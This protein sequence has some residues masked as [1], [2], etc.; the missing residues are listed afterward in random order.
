[1]REKK[2]VWG[3]AAVAPKEYP[4]EIYEGALVNRDGYSYNFGPIYGVLRQGWGY[5]A[6]GMGITDD[7]VKL[8]DQLK[9]TWYSVQEQQFYT[10]RWKL[11]KNLI[12]KVWKEVA[13]NL[14]TK[15]KENFKTLIVGMAPRGQV[16]LWGEGPAQVLLG[17]FQA[18]DTII[19]QKDANPDFEHFFRK[20]YRNAAYDPYKL[21][22][23]ELYS[24]LQK[25]GWPDPKIYLDFNKKYPW[26]FAI[27]GIEASEDD[28][29][30]YSSFNGERAQVL[31][32]REINNTLPKAAPEHIYAC[33]QDPQHNQWVAT[34]RFTYDEIKSSFEHFGSSE[35]IEFLFK[36]DKNAGQFTIYLQSK[37]KKIKLTGYEPEL[38]RT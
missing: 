29:F 34:I 3:G 35:K 37:N 15:S 7:P 12:T 2:Y 26:K 6:K 11:D 33:W 24:K 14:R 28:Y 19:S 13:I 10:G 23:P 38:V 25:A 8:P 36:I 18:H 9:M 31:N 30:F 5:P 17:T 22:G 4:V 27:E 20:E 16:T 32:T 21:Y 1:V